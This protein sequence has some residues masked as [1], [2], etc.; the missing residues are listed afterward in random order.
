MPIQKYK[1]TSPG[2]RGMSVA[3]FSDLTTDKPTKSLVHGKKRKSGRNSQGRITTRHMGGGHKKLYRLVDF[4]R[5]KLDIPA[6]IKSLEYDPNRT[7]RIC[8][9]VYA[10]GAKRY[11]LAPKGI[12]VGDPIISS[13][14]ADI[15]LGNCL[16]LSN[17][18][19]G[20]VVHNVELKPLKGGQL[21]RSAGSGATLTSK[22][23]GYAYLKLRSGEVRRVL[24]G[25]R[26][27]IGEV[28]NSE[29]NLVKV[30]KA[31]RQ[32]WKGI[33][34]TVRGVAM[35]PVDHPHGGGEGK[36]SGGRHPVSPWG[37]PTKGAKTRNNKST[38]KYIVSR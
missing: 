4:K 32:R 24:L 37:Q 34:P 20:T 38:D 8:L 11:I 3:D 17:I 29:H 26:A 33:R 23:N 31:G 7:A 21:V 30:G 9:V 28:G 19:T 25:C 27:T 5:E 18:P 22:E 12:Q 35:N 14:K 13:D 6:T 16:L 1:P 36:S 10:D 15:Q 2:R